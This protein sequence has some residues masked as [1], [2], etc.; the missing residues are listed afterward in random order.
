MIT[1]TQSL[2]INILI[3]NVCGLK[4]KLLLNEFMVCIMNYDILCMCET[5]C[6]DADMSN[7]IN[8]MVDK[9]FDIVYKNRCSLSRY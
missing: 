7:I 3:I 2:C 5:R 8:V 9:R 6:D 1:I 4:S